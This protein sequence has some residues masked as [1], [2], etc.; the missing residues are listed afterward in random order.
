[1]ATRQTKC[2]KEEVSGRC[3]RG[4]HFVRTGCECVCALS[5]THTHTT[6]LLS[7]VGDVLIGYAR[8]DFWLAVWNVEYGYEYI[9]RACLR[10]G[11]PNVNVIMFIQ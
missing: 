1:M 11:L 3:N 8:N 6:V 7:G 4:V 9:K 5:H 2:A 10:K